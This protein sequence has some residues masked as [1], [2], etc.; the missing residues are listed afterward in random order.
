MIHGPYSSPDVNTAKS[1]KPKGRPRMSR[2]A[3]TDR[4]DPKCLKVLISAMASCSFV[5][6]CGKLDNTVI[7]CEDMMR[8]YLATKRQLCPERS[9]DFGIGELAIL[10]S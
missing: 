8:F 6:R 10:L 9:S 3:L 1:T 7:I 2:D 5:I 4:I